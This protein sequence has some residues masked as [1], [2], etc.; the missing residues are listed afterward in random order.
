MILLYSRKY[1]IDC[2]LICHITNIPRR[3][4]RSS[5]KEGHLKRSS[6]NLYPGKIIHI[7]R[8]GRLLRCRIKKLYKTYAL[9]DIEGQTD[10]I[11]FKEILEDGYAKSTRGH[12]RENQ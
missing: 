6:I 12:K 3:P 10:I 8:N 9:C 2:Y 1:H 7:K 11:L 4:A 5:E